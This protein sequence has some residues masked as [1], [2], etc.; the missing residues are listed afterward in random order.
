MAGSA[1]LCQP[2]R[3]H[4]VSV[5][6]G[7]MQRERAAQVLRRR[8]LV[9]RGQDLQNSSGGPSQGEMGQNQGS[10]PKTSSHLAFIYSAVL[11][12]A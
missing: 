4:P 6:L 3:G 7:R 10:L 11:P 2:T 9:P 1:A 12:E 5:L 8:T